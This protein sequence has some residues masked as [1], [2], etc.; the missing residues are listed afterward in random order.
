MTYGPNMRSLILTKARQLVGGEFD[1]MMNHRDK[2]D[3]AA[4][5]IA[6]VESSIRIARAESLV[7]GNMD[8]E[9][10]DDEFI[11]G[12]I[13]RAIQENNLLAHFPGPS[14]ARRT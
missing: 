8:D 5:A 10:W 11:A 13:L 4:E 14:A 12:E 9:S 6:A 1:L 7:A 2:V 3:V